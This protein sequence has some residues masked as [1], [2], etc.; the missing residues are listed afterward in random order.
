MAARSIR[1]AFL[2]LASWAMLFAPGAAAQADGG[3]APEIDPEHV[4]AAVIAPTFGA[5]GVVVAARS[6][7]EDGDPQVDATAPFAHLAAPPARPG[8]G[9]TCARDA[10]AT[11]VA[12]G[13]EHRRRAPARA[14]PTD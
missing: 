13:S 12:G 3:A 1:I 8:A 10:V 14:P 11:G 2:A 4:A 6:C 7:R 9:R 5:D